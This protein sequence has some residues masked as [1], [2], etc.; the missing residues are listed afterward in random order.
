MSC[1]S[2][3]N[4]R[5][6]GCVQHFKAAIPCRVPRCPVMGRLPVRIRVPED[7]AVRHPL[8]S[9]LPCEFDILYHCIYL[10]FSIRRLGSARVGFWE[11]LL[12][13]SALAF[14]LLLVLQWTS[15]SHE[16]RT[17][18]R[19]LR[20]EDI[21]PA[22]RPPWVWSGDVVRVQS[23]RFGHVCL[24]CYSTLF[25]LT[26]GSSALAQRSR[27]F[28][29]AEIQGLSGATTRRLAHRRSE[30]PGSFHADGLALRSILAWA[31][32]T[33]DRQC[34]HPAN[35]AVTDP[36]P[37]FNYLVSTLYRYPKCFSRR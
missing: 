35:R 15:S 32:T 23:R 11:F 37:P 14:T 24:W 17:I 21:P 4:G 13:F 1:T 31:A 19:T 26:A 6:W 36:L 9:T 12:W 2:F 20:L 8:P 7:V 5:R 10:L 30:G 22:E 18:E 34:A 16:V 25:G 29:V 33:G 3:P 28:R 27:G